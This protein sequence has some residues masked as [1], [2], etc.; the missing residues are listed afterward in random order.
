MLVSRG[1]HMI[2][3]KTRR[4]IL[5]Q[6]ESLDQFCYAQESALVLDAALEKIYGAGLLN[7]PSQEY[8]NFSHV[9][10]EMHKDLW[11]GRTAR[12]WQEIREEFNVTDILTLPEI[13]LQLPIIAE[14]ADMTLY[15]IPPR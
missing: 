12:Q 9:P 1:F 13:R 14:N 7:P 11:A 5:I 4:P 2:V 10:I 8:R 6:A 15:S 3:P